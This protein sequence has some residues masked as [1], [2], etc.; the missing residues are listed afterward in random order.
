MN[1]QTDKT[2]TFDD[3]TKEIGLRTEIIGNIPYIPLQLIKTV[4]MAMFIKTLN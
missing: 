2:A 1:K 4:Y 3:I